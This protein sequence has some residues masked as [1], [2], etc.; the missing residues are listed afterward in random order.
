MATITVPN[1]QDLK[2][3]DKNNKNKFDTSQD[4]N[5][6]F[7]LH[8]VQ[9]KIES[10]ELTGI[11]SIEFKDQEIVAVNVEPEEVDYETMAE[12]NV[13]NNV[14][15]NNL[16]ENISTLL[17]HNINHHQKHKVKYIPNK[18]VLLK[19]FFFCCTLLST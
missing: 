17:F 19:F 11:E 12:A 9:F 6:T 1:L 3:K 10:V 18:P 5:K 2:F 14:Y 7:Q 13:A 8:K 15:N 4:S 16:L